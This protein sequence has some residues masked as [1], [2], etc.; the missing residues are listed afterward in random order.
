[1]A[2]QERHGDFAEGERTKPS[3]PGERDFAEGEERERPGRPR[4][5]GEGI[6]HE[7]SEHEGSF[8]D[9]EKE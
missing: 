3:E 1:M 6:E 4:D 2:D 8:A 9:G 7:H 5:F